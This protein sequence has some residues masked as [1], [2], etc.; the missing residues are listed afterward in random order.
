MATPYPHAE[1]P[2]TESGPPGSGPRPHASPWRLSPRGDPLLGVRVTTPALPRTFVRRPRLLGLLSEGVRKPLVLVNG[3]AGAGKTL[4]VADWFAGPLPW[5][6]AWLTVS[7]DDNAPGLFWAYVLEALRRCGVPLPDDVGSPARSDEVDR[8]LLSRLA[9]QLGALPQPVLLVLDEYDRVTSPEVAAQ[10]HFVLRHAGSGLRLVLIS[11]S[12]PLLPLHRYRAAD[13]IAEVRAADLAF[14]PDETAVLLHRHGLPQSR[15]AARAL[16]ERTEGWAAGLR[17]FAL[18]MLRTPYADTFAK[19]F[20]AGHSVVADFL[21]SEVLATQPPRTQDLLLRTSILDQT[22]PALANALTGR[23]DGE[24]ILASLERANAFVTSVGHRWYRLHPL[25][26][27]VL[28]ARLRARHPGLERELHR[29]AARWLCDAGLLGDALPH[30]AA[31]G[32]WEFAAGRF[33]GDLA[34][35]RLFTGVDMERL[36]ALFSGMPREVPG[37]APELVRAARELARYDVDRGLLHLRRAAERLGDDGTDES[38]AA[39]L[40]HAFLRVMAGGLLGAPD[41]AGNAAREAD[42]LMRCVA[43]ERIADHPELTALLLTALGS[44]E[45]WAGR[46]DSAR[47]RLCAAVAV[48]DSA[49][50][51]WPRHEASGRVALIDVLHGCLRKAESRAR[52]A[53]EVAERAGLA[54]AH[55]SGIAPLVLAAVALERADPAAAR[56]ALARAEEASGAAADPLVATSLTVLRSRLALARGDA[57][58]ALDVLDG[59]EARS[60]AGVA[61]PWAGRHLAVARSMALLARG[62][63]AAALETLGEDAAVSPECAVAAACARLEAGDATAALGVLDAV[64]AATAGG[65][66][67]AV[68]MLLLR[69]RI[70]QTLGDEEAAH[71]IVGRALRTGRPELLRLAFLESGAWLRRLLLRRPDLAE[72]WLPP[73]LLPDCARTPPAVPTPA[74]LVEPLSGREHDVLKCAAQMMS[75]EEIAAELHLSVN[76]VKTHLKSVHRKLSASRRGEAVRRARDLHLL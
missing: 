7:S 65:P 73:V 15:E 3:P 5:P 18:A 54:P 62:D 16:T 30:A 48:S 46:P 37:A 20:E 58:V 31:A 24:W 27:E 49:G 70:A 71:R 76:T 68:R 19:E 35:G 56:D 12:E 10:L 66:G 32:D 43:A 9:A 44:T 17:L 72:D 42:G 59:A 33:V 60:A 1:S 25:C 40:T 39:R 64:P 74:A 45:L 6:A 63:P 36:G 61:S 53:L 14:T 8:A 51:A 13:D 29:R 67:P 38:A 21:L 57:R 47:D 22:H 28:R 2:G 55:C 34:V 52:E 75:T 41:L 23:E 69:A 11:R 26:A 50:T 4:L